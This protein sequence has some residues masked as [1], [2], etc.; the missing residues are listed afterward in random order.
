VALRPFEPNEEVD[1][2]RWLAPDDARQLLTFERDR[3]VI[4]A[5]LAWDR[6]IYLVRHARAGSSAAWLGDDA[7]RPL[8]GKGLRQ[9]ARLSSR[10]GSIGSLAFVSSPSVRCVQTLEPLAAA[11]GAV[12]CRAPELADDTPAPVVDR[13]LRNLAGPVVV[14]SH[15][16]PI[17]AVLSMWAASG[18]AVEGP[19]REG[20]PFAKKGSTWIVERRAGAAVALRYVPPPRDR[21]S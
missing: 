6:P 7:E 9:A 12:I 21:A 4:D 16:K 2:L 3:S 10:L 8:T 13:F 17:E 20:V 14:S 11:V 15:G 18:I 19:L 1:E 5:S